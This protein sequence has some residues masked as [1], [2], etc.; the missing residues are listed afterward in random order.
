MEV[1]GGRGEL[2][3]KNL[4]LS[5]LEHFMRMGTE[6]PQTLAVS[7]VQKTLEGFDEYVNKRTNEADGKKRR[8]NPEDFRVVGPG[9]SWVSSPVRRQAS[10]KQLVW[11][12]SWIN[13][14]IQP[15]CPHSE[16]DYH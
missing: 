12:T 14:I 10:H 1:D 9:L 7:N 5:T 2:E 3:S 6:H 8:D 15:S 16:P 11:G 4:F 13:P